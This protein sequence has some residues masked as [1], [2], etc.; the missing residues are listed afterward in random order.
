MSKRVTLAPTTLI[1]VVFITAATFVVKGHNSAVTCFQ[2]DDTSITQET[3]PAPD[4]PPTEATVRGFP[5]WYY[6]EPLPLDC[7][8][9]DG[10]ASMASAS[11]SN[12]NGA[13]FAGDLLIWI[14]L[15]FPISLGLTKV[16]AKK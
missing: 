4:S 13:H 10:V 3:K 12:F 15:A 9:I 6:Q 16:R 1:L 7:M 5:F 2:S 11:T 8:T 14:L